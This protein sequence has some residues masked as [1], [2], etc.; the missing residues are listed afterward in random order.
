MT[1]EATI[2]RVQDAVLLGVL[3]APDPASAEK[4]AATLVEAGIPGV[5]VTFSTPDAARVIAALRHRYGQDAVVGA[6]T[7]LTAA[8]AR[9]AVDAGAEYLVSPGMDPP[10]VEAMLATGMTVMAGAL[11]PTEVLA[12]LRFGVHVVKLFP[13]SLGGPAYLRAL[14][15][16]FPDIPFMPTGG[17]STDNLADWL[18]AGAVALGAGGELISSADLAAG[19][20]DAVATKARRFAAAIGA[21]RS[22]VPR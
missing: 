6:G 5:E 19:D 12:G 14:R 7:V 11:T 13:A 1:T 22:E 8:Q 18:A 9:A 4:A 20:Y 16:P 21:A 2:A 10:I 3:R 15:G 17:V